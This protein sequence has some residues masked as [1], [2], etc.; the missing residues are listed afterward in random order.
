MMGQNRVPQGQLSSLYET[1][2]VTYYVWH[3]LLP[4]ATLF[5]RSS[6][7]AEAVHG[8]RFYLLVTDAGK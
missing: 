1:G 3:Q 4:I 7:L 8:H 2:Y 5:S 6:N